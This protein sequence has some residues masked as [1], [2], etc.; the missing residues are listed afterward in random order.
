[1]TPTDG[2][3][4]LF[5]A[6]DQVTSQ[7]KKLIESAC[8]LLAGVALFA[9]MALTFF[10]VGGRKLLVPFHHRFAGADRAADGRGDFCGAA[11]GV[12]AWR[13]HVVFDSLDNVPA[14]CA[15]AWC[16]VCWCTCCAAQR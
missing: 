13:A 1:V 16:N 9:I 5:S 12:A 4:R 15:Q 10:D 11:P 14:G 6:F 2:G 7:L 3:R 8:G